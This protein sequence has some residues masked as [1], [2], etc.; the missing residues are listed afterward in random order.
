[1]GSMH[2]ISQEQH[3]Y[4]CVLWWMYQVRMHNSQP[5]V[6]ECNIRMLLISV[7]YNLC[8]EHAC[9][10]LLYTKTTKRHSNSTRT[11][12]SA[13]TSPRTVYIQPVCTSSN[14][15]TIACTQMENRA[16]GHIKCTMQFYMLVDARHCG[17]G[18]MLTCT[19]AQILICR[20]VHIHMQAHCTAPRIRTQPFLATWSHT[21]AHVHAGTVTDGAINTCIE[22]TNVC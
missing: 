2:F 1:M 19:H 12:I 22:R 9:K 7:K 20:Y 5:A 8:L 16:A 17:G 21:H 18:H 15:G 11:C 13:M 6:R 4:V 10:Q 3:T 14:W